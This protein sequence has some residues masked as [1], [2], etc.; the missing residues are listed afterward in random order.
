[1][2]GIFRRSIIFSASSLGARLINLCTLSF[3]L[4]AV[5][6]DVYGA[7][8]YHLSL[9]SVA[10]TVGL[11][12]TSALLF[13]EFCHGLRHACNW[14]YHGLIVR[15]SGTA[16]ALALAFVWVSF[17]GQHFDRW[18]LGSCALL[19]IGESTIVLNS[20]WLRAR[21][22]PAMELAVTF[23]RG[24]L[25]LISI[26]S[27]LHLFPS[28]R[29]IALG[30]LIGVSAVLL[31]ILWGWRRALRIG[32]AQPFVFG[33]M[34]MPAGTILMLEIMGVLYTE[35]PVLILGNGGAFATS[36]V[37]SVYFRF[38]SV[39]TLAVASYDQSFQ[40]DFN[41]TVRRDPAMARALLAKGTRFMLGIGLL[42][43]VG[44]LAVGPLVL[45]YAAHLKSIDWALV[46]AYA[47]LPLANGFASMS[48]NSLIA[49]KKER[50]ILVSHACGLLAM[51]G[52]MALL[53]GHPVVRA[54][55]AL[56][57]AFFAKALIARY[58]LQKELPKNLPDHGLS[59][60]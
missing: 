20:G 22:R 54:T 13:R 27:A 52:A 10:L 46:S 53:K 1:M 15:C 9:L 60:N 2:S 39:A 44:V 29:G 35:L 23:S 36:G 3:I 12:G 5:G 17:R 4:A 34:I 38:L 25:V 42:S 57:I 26:V 55:Y 28:T 7:Y 59:Q 33:E 47:A 49:L 18:L 21:R 50:L 8:Q 43:G 48:D 11:L 32:R 6:T 37:Y 40:S 45:K 58:F 16:L 19:V 24:L 41:R 51:L 56:V 31:S 14:L 30:Y